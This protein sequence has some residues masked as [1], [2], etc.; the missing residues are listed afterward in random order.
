MLIINHPVLELTFLSQGKGGGVG[1]SR[2]ESCRSTCMEERLVRRH[3]F[4]V[5]CGVTSTLFYYCGATYSE[6]Y[7]S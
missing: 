2:V 1:S 4:Q 5:M 7:V 3:V 6:L